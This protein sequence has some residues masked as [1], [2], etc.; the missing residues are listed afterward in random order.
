L[1]TA[2][3]VLP[4]ANLDPATLRALNDKVRARAARFPS[5]RA[6]TRC[7]QAYEKRKNAALD[8]ERL[9]REAAAV[10]DVKKLDALIAQL[11]DLSAGAKT[12]GRCGAIMGLAGVA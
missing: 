2:A 8:L 6:H 10:D 3:P 12:D 11:C 7:S 9:V 1:L 4:A 5:H